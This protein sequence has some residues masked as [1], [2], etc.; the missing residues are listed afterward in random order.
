MKK[1]LNLKF[2]K[3]FL[4]ILIISTMIGKELQ[5]RLAELKVL[6]LAPKIVQNN[7]MSSHGC[8]RGNW[9]GVVVCFQ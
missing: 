2:L 4:I 6:I 1:I 5:G 8:T 7:V 9:Q 3:F